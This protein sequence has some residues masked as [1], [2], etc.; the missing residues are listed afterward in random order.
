MTVE[1]KLDLYHRLFKRMKARA[2]LMSTAEKRTY[3]RAVGTNELKW[4]LKKELELSKEDL[5]HD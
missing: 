1:E 3:M 4:I 2:L 5:K